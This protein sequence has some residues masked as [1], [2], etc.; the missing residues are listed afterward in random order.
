MNQSEWELKESAG[1]QLFQS[2]F[3]CQTRHK[4]WYLSADLS[5][6]IQHLQ[7]WEEWKFQFRKVSWTRTFRYLVWGCHQCR[8]KDPFN[9][10]SEWAQ[11]KA[12]GSTQHDQHWRV[13]Q[14][15]RNKIYISTKLNLLSLS[16]TWLWLF[17]LQ[18]YFI[19][20][21]FNCKNM[22][23]LCANDAKL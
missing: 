1:C 21:W 19:I 10:F 9:I 11:I 3:T 8:A 13:V 20:S 18:G 14:L 23:M 6:I 2:N 22:V 17:R 16:T 5:K 15:S 4:D 12:P 7:G